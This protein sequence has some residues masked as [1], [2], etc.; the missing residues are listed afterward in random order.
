LALLEFVRW[1]KPLHR[2]HCF[3][4]LLCWV[5]FCLKTDGWKFLSSLWLRVLRDVG[6]FPNQSSQT[7]TCVYGSN[8]LS[9]NHMLWETLCKT[10]W[11][12]IISRQMKTFGLFAFKIICL[13][14]DM[15]HLLCTLGECLRGRFSN[16]HDNVSSIFQWWEMYSPV[17]HGRWCQCCWNACVG[18]Q[19]CTSCSRIFVCCHVF[20]QNVGLK[21]SGMG[22]RG[23]TDVG[24]FSKRS[25]DTCTSMC[26]TNLLSNTHLWVC[27]LGKTCWLK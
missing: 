23:Y 6:A 26:S 21:F 9:H 19:H 16:H 18:M 12:K 20:G 27:S 2:L 3:T 4:C 22:L 13:L 11:L 25:H 8:L 10:C 15:T 24:A 17:Q 5:T 14:H 1:D 7:C